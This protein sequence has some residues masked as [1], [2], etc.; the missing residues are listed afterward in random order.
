M[1]S[2]RVLAEELGRLRA[3]AAANEVQEKALAQQRKEAE[4]AIPILEQALA[5]LPG[6]PVLSFADANRIPNRVKNCLLNAEISIEQAVEM[7]DAE[8]LGLKNFGKVALHYVRTGETVDCAALEPRVREVLACGVTSAS[9][10]A[11]SLSIPVNSCRT[12]LHR[13]R[14][15]KKVYK[16]DCPDGHVEWGIRD[17]AD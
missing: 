10:I 13:L 14:R 7:S 6:P 3:L 2:G 12:V 8:L 4:A 9:E 11:K 16:R 1:H 5:A 17:D 15:A